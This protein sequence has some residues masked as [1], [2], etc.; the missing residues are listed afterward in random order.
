MNWQQLGRPARHAGQTPQ[1][2]YGS[3]VTLSPTWIESGTSDPL[4]ATTALIVALIETYQTA[5]GTVAIPEVL[6]PYMPR[7]SELSPP[8]DGVPFV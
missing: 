1:W 6:R 8:A 7:I 5:A 4:S 2:V 3:T